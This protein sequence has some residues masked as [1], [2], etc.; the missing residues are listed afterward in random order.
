MIGTAMD[1]TAK[2]CIYNGRRELRG[3]RVG[4]LGLART[5]TACVRFLCQRGALVTALDSAR[6]VELP[7]DSREAAALAHRVVA[8]YSHADDALPLDMLIVSPGVPTD[9]DIVRRAVEAGVEVIGELELGYRFCEA[10]MVAVTGTSGKG[11][12]VMALGALLGAAGIRHVVAGNIGLPLIGEVGRSAELDVVVVEVSSYQLDTTVH[13]HPHIAILLNVTQDHLER[14]ASFEA[15]AAAKQAI[16][17]NQSARDWA[18]LYTDDPRVEEMRDQL[19]A[20]TLRVSTRDLEADAYLAGGE[21][22]LRMR[23]GVPQAAVSHDALPMAG[24][25]HVVDF[26]AASLAASLCGVEPG[27]IGPT[28][29]RHSHAP[30]LMEVVCEHEGV[31]YIN[32]SKA[33]NP[34]SALADL[35]GIAG[36]V[37]VI[38][39]GKEKQTDFADFGKALAGQAKAVVLM[40]ECAARIEAAVN[41]AQICH[42]AGSMAEAVRIAADL[43]APG[44][45]VALCPGCSSLDQFE[46]YAHRGDEFARRARALR[47]A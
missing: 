40:G 17:R 25:H 2:A 35:S 5:G 39:G 4:V 26:L 13:F 34:A 44:D 16:F 42:V 14:Y 22:V 12:T 41:R 28:L 47:K 46:S 36:P 37:I 24:K 19:A 1:E 33:T 21:L 7:S 30:H 6:L 9:A 31:V 20:R 38:V 18:I 3:K 15:Y 8:P 45:T 11:T 10:P 27:H 23:G 29:S 43:A 32:D